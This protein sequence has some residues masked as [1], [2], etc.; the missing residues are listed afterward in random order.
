MTLDLRDLDALVLE[1]RAIARNQNDHFVELYE[2]ESALARSVRTFLSVGVNDG[3]AAVVIATPAHREA[4]EEELDRT[5]DLDAAREQGLY[6]ALDASHTLSLF[7]ADGHIDAERFISVIGGVL[8]A[9]GRGG[10]RVR[11]FGEMVALLWEQGDVPAALELEDR[12]NELADTHAF[13]LFC[14]YPA[15]GFDTADTTTLTG[16]CNRHSHVVVPAR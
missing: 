7:S 1:P 13:R 3:D 4:I 16:V 6:R 10:R 11:V 14:A 5:M 2:D 12:W 15:R 8:G 9:A